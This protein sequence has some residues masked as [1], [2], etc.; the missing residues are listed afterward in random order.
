MNEARNESRRR[1][2]SLGLAV[3]LPMFASPSDRSL[4]VERADVRGPNGP[5]FDFCSFWGHPQLPFA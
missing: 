2:V 5:S 1:K 4:T 3:C